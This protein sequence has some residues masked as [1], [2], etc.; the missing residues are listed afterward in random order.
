MRR[1]VWFWSELSPLLLQFCKREGLSF[2]EVVNL[3]VQAFLGKCDLRE[4]RLRARVAELL[5]EE[6]ELRR[7]CS[8]MLR[9]GAYLP[10]YAERV[11]KTEK[12]KP[13][14]RSP[15]RFSREESDRPLA[16]LSR[17][18]EK[19][20]RKI[21]ARRE[22]IAREV[23]EV[24]AQLLKGV[25]PFVLPDESQSRVDRRENLNGGEKRDG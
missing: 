10:G 16:C 18:E 9:S 14:E 17:S 24:Q 15:F 11:L 12:G 20:F 19:V 25:K 22:E 7:V 3:A 2:N 23:A 21:C 13:L 8:C 1:N 4:L 6:V 5:R